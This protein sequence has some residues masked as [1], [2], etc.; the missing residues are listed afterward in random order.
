MSLKLSRNK[1]NYL[2]RLIIEYIENNE[3]V[4]YLED[5]GNIRMKL[6]HLI[7]DELRLYEN[8]EF[9]AKESVNS[10]KKNIPEGSREWEILF[11]KYANEELNKLGKIWD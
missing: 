6:F 1:V 7:M 5:I 10:Q 11:R 4:D 2:C 3:E 8:I 9:R